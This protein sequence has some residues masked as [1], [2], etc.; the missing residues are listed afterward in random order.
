MWLIQKYTT[1]ALTFNPVQNQLGCFLAP[2]VYLM[3]LGCI[4]V[5]TGSSR[6]SAWCQPWAGAVCSDWCGAVLWQRGHRAGLHTGTQWCSLLP[7]PP[8]LQP[9]SGTF[10]EAGCLG[11]DEGHERKPISL[12]WLQ[13][14]P[15]VIRLDIDI[16]FLD[17]SLSHFNSLEDCSSPLKICT[18][19]RSD[20]LSCEMAV[21]LYW[22]LRQFK[23]DSLDW[24]I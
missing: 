19:E 21:S 10:Q 12:H 18:W 4:S 5:G 1:V 13:R 16:K 15:L 3:L 7:E 6:G 23:V 2:D 17:G 24:D 8:A 14:K 22:P 11:D 20:E 9:G